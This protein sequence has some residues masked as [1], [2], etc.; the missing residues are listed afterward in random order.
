MEGVLP[1][2]I[3]WRPKSGFT[4][5]ARAWL[6][7]PL[8]PLVDELLSPAAVRERGLF[9]PHEV[10]RMIDANARAE[11]DNAL[12]IWTLLTLELW[13]RTFIDSDGSRPVDGVGGLTTPAEAR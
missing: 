10:R 1:D 7:G 12:R 3:I 6:V 5:P 9:D 11:A 13:Q 2:S 4:A 8:S